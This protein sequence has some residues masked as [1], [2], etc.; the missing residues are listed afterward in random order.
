MNTGYIFHWAEPKSGKSG[1]ESNFVFVPILTGTS[2]QVIKVNTLNEENTIRLSNRELEQMNTDVWAKTF[3]FTT[4]QKY[5]NQI[6]ILV[7]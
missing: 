1:K 3:F 7:S 5:P 6:F 4:T 2:E